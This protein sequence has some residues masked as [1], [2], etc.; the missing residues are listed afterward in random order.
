MAAIFSS[1]DKIV[2]YF[3]VLT[4]MTQPYPKIH[5]A[6]NELDFWKQL[7]EA[8]LEPKQKPKSYFMYI[9]KPLSCFM[10]SFPQI[11]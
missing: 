1:K 7:S 10:C 6:G 2:F 11:P 8:H 3:L 5:L 4:H 9:Y